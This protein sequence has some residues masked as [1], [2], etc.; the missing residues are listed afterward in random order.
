MPLHRFILIIPIFFVVSN[1]RTQL[2]N[3]GV[4]H[5]LM[6]MGNMLVEKNIGGFAKSGA[7]AMD[8]NLETP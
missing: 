2:V 1:Y 7:I 6:R 8:V 3:F 5:M 4:Q